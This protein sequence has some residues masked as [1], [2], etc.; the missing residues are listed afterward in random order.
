MVDWVRAALRRAAYHLY[1]RACLPDHILDRLQIYRQHFSQQYPVLV[2]YLA[3]P[4]CNSTVMI[5]LSNVVEGE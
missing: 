4:N 2:L 5:I 3:H 1:V